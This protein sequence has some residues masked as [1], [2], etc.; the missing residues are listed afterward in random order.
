MSNRGLGNRVHLN[1][2]TATGEDPNDN[3]VEDTDDEVVTTEQDPN[4]SLVKT[5]NPQAFVNVGETITYT[6]TITN[7]GN[8][9]LTNVVI[10]DPLTGSVDLAVTPST[11][12]PTQT[13]TATATYAITQADIDAGQVLNTATATG[14]D[15]GGDTVEDT[16]DETIQ[17]PKQ[18]PAITVVKTAD[19]QTYSAVGDIITYTFS[20]TNTGNV[21]L[22]NVVIND[23]LTGS[24][25][26]AVSPSTLGPNQTGTATATYTITQADLDAS[27]VLNTATATGEDPNDNPVEDTDDED[28]DAYLD[29]EINLVKTADPQS[30]SNP[31]ETITYTFTVTNTGNLTLTDVVIND[32]LTGSVDLAVTPSTLAPTEVGTAT[33][34]YTITQAD[35]DAGQVL[36]TATATGDDPNDNPVEDTDDES[37]DG[38]EHAPEI[39]LVKSADPGVY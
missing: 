7:T 27:Q 35:I 22:T 16:D 29:P 1:I 39:S 14:E 36:N 25:D 15:P 38:P 12:A 21:T 8:V 24:V 34:T 19:P 20:V 5:A 11:L 37:I 18:E 31:G 28:V 17:G 33:A 3:P 32:L 9:T 30:Y 2:A 13:G 10:N 4:I 6:F 26:L 23:P